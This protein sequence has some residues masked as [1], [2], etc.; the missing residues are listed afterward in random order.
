MFISF[1]NRFLISGG[2]LLTARAISSNWSAVRVSKFSAI[3]PMASAT[4]SGV[5]CSVRAV[6]VAS[7]GSGSLGGSTAVVV[8]FCEG[9]VVAV[10][11]VVTVDGGLMPATLV[12]VRGVGWVEFTISAVVD[13]MPVVVVDNNR[14]EVDADDVGNKVWGGWLV[15]V[16]VEDGSVTVLVDDEE[17]LVEDVSLVGELM[18]VVVVSGHVSSV[19]VVVSTG[20]VVDGAVVTGVEG[21]LPVNNSYE[22]VQGCQM[23]GW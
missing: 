4:C 12:V 19:V 11:T 18:L 6:N 8:G 23:S 21:T 16:V 15:V 9:L 1:S 3:S 7:S 2:A 10:E 20:C 14:V 17:E 5:A 22:T 13:G